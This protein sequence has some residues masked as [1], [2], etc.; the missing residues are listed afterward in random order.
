MKPSIH[1][2]VFFGGALLLCVA[3]LWLRPAPP[4]QSLATPGVVRPAGPP[5]AP[6]GVAAAVLARYA[7]SYELDSTTTVTISVE[8]RRLFAQA[9][10]SPLLELLAASDT[11]FFLK[12]SDV[13]LT[14]E[15]DAQGN[16][17][18]FIVRLPN[19]DLTAERVR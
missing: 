15:V 10:G 13:E 18:G 12:D 4:L 7:G 5:R 16:A 11:E 2:A 3:W 8:D 1:P 14:F 6:V 9:S 17:E 19:G